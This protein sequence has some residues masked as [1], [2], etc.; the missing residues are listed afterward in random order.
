MSFRKRC[1]RTWEWNASLGN[2]P[3]ID[4]RGA[5]S[6]EEE[7]QRKKAKGLEAADAARPFAVKKLHLLAGTFD[8]VDVKRTVVHQMAGDFDFL[9]EVGVGVDCVLVVDVQN[10]L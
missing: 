3:R 6:A 8:F 7:T 10:G 2:E 4:R 9:A 5:E 1:G